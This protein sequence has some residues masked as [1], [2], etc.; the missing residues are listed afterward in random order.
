VLVEGDTILVNPYSIMASNPEIFPWVKYDLA[1]KLI[2]W[3]CSP[4][5]Q[6]LIGKFT[7]RGSKLFV[8]TVER[9][10]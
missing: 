10:N 5:G 7:V 1:R 6:L 9:E 2:D 3:L 4:D 8:P